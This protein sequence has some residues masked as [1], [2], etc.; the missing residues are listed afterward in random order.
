M[1]VRAITTV[2]ADAVSSCQAH[3]G[4]SAQRTL[5][6]TVAFDFADELLALSRPVRVQITPSQTWDTKAVSNSFLVKH[7]VIDGLVGLATCGGLM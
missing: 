5:L 3:G 7:V 6:C 1:F 4:F 2:V